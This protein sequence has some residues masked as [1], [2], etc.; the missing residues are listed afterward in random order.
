MVRVCV[1]LEAVKSIVPE[2]WVK[3]PPTS[4]Q[5]PATDRVP[6]VEVNVPPERVKAPVSVIAAVEPLN[7]PAD[8]VNEVAAKVLAF[9]LT[10]ML[11]EAKLK[12]AMFTAAP[13]VAVPVPDEE[14]K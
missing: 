5:L 9:K 1:P 4:F 8:C 14:L 12:A 13:T 2:L 11:D 3:V 7:V 10:V 6:E